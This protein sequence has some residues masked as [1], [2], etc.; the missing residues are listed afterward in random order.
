ME[1]ASI[2]DE[3]AAEPEIIRRVIS[4]EKEEFRHLVELHQGKVFAMIV[5]QLGDEQTAKELAQEV[6][7][8]AYL[9]LSSFRFEASF[10]TW[11]IRITLNVTNS[12]FSSKRYKTQMKMTTFEDKHGERIA[13][14][15][16]RPYDQELIDELR[17]AVANLKPKYREALVLCAFENKKYEEAATIL[18]I[19]V[20]TVRSRLNT[21]RLLL[22]DQ[23]VGCMR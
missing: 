17:T 6:F 12:Y 2:G 11:L 19:P 23:L 3:S 20:G 16:D 9:N 21:A 15:E 7:L 1:I 13:E 22:K 10:S 8:K 14:A 5:R 18:G 4:G